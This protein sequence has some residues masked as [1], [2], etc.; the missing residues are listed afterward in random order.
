MGL[1]QTSGKWVELD[2]YGGKLTENLVQA[3][4][5]DLLASAMRN[6]LSISKD[7]EVGIVGHIHDELITEC[8]EDSDITL[9]DVCI[10]MSILPDWAKPFDIPLRAEGFNSY[11][12]KKD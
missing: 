10:A 1:D 6:V 11:F 7:G 12:Y 3:V 5:R 9:D 8:P 4:S 2:T